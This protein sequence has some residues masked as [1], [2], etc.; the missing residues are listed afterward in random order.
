MKKQRKP[1]TRAEAYLTASMK[2]MRKAMPELSMEQFVIHNLQTL[3]GMEREE[4]LE[5]TPHDKG[6]GYYERSLRSLMKN[7]IV[8]EV[9]RTRNNGFAP[10]AMQLFKMSQEQ[11]NDLCLTL[12]KKGMTTRDISDV[13][14]SYFG[15]AMSHTTINKLAEQFHDIRLAWERSPLD[16]T[17]SVVYADCIFVT[18]RRDDSYSN[19]AVYICYGVNSEN[20]REL[21][22]LS[23]N[24]TESATVWEEVFA[25]MKSRGVKQT[26]LVIADGLSGMESS[27]LKAFAGAEF[28]KC[29]VH[30]M[31]SIML[32]VRPKDKLAVAEDLKNVFDNFDALAT[33]EKALQKVETFCLKWEGKYSGIRQ[34]FREG[35]REY[36]F[37]YIK[38]PPEVRRLIYTN[39]SIENLNRSIRKG[40]KNKLSFENPETLLDYVFIIIKEFES[41]NWSRYPVHQFSFIHTDQTQLS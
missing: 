38:F 6:N 39:N 9:P 12:Y 16:E 33:L 20:K 17:Y 37:T 40:T 7:G 27:V 35:T 21:L 36:Y 28:Q 31:R 34:H 11:V 30:K 32:T 2:N 19:E 41:K 18:V 1:P 4:Y 15:N 8:I 10:I 24:P 25:E 29:V 23:V 14:E 5:Q 13:M 3:F 26:R 22:A